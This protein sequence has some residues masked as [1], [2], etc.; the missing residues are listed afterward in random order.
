MDIRER[1]ERASLVRDAYPV[2]KDFC[3][4]AMQFLGFEMTWMQGDMADWM[5]YGPANQMT[6]AQRGEAKS[7]VACIFAV[8]CLVRN[9]ACRVLLVSGAQSKADEN[10]MLIYGL[11]HK[12]DRLSYLIPDRYAGDRVST[13]EFDVHYSL[14]G[15]EKSAS[16]NCIGITASLQGL[17]ADILIPDD[18]ETTK[19]GLTAQQ[20][21]NLE[22]LSKEFSSIADHGRIMYLGT[23]QT[24]DSIYNRLPQRGFEVRIWPGRF[25]TLEQEAAY[26]VHLAPS[27]KERMTL[28]GD[29][30]R[31][32]GGLDG[33][34]GW[35]TD[36][37]RFDEATLCS[38]E[39]DQGPEGF[40]LQY[41]LNTALMD[42]MRQQLKV[43]DLVVGD[44]AHDSVP[45]VCTWAADPRL[46][47]PAPAGLEVLKP[48]LYRPGS[49]SEH[50]TAPKNMT[51]TVDPASDGGDELAFA[52][53]GIVGP[54]MHCVGWGGFRGGFADKNLEKLVVLVRQFDVKHVVVEK[55]MGA[56]AVT[57]LIQNYFNGQDENGKRRIT[58]V[59]VSEKNA[60]G[61]KERRII[62]SIRPILQR[63]RLVMHK[64]A[65]DMDAEL[66]AEYPADR[67]VTYSGLYQMHNITTDRGSLTKD[68]RIDALEQL[69][70]ELVDFLVLDEEKEAA[71]RRKAEAQIFINDPMGTSQFK[72]TRSRRNNSIRALRR[73]FK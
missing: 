18:I 64:S 58:G 31:S 28:L 73:R 17:R 59:A 22:H 19:N 30:C 5:Q 4:D 43:R 27:I 1:L 61:Q 32:G 3:R 50:F 48:E 11:I 9:P 24:K 47:W 56:G 13:C 34:R 45:E 67:R 35:P 63:H 12:W 16:V 20:R 57:R 37:H 38:K 70:R 53:G 42:A 49:M 72:P 46:Q 8:W 2:F 10:G 60:T 44:F 29:K 23:P 15:I 54:Y 26:G 25:P 33:S 69:C 39:L 21:A 14:R 68:D 51:M 41:M 65:I 52:I 36:P 40:E 66:I 7:T 55:N 62:D 6:E 71:T